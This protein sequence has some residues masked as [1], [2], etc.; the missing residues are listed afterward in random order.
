MNSFMDERSGRRV[1]IIQTCSGVREADIENSVLTA[2]IIRAEWINSLKD[3]SI[4]IYTEQY[5]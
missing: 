2:L 5:R 3:K 4:K 1:W